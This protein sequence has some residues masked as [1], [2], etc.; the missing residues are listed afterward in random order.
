MVERTEKSALYEQLARVGKAVS[1]PARLELLDLLAQAPRT[2]E[3]LAGLTRLSVANTSQHLQVLRAAG[4]VESSKDGL[5]VT[6][7]LAS[8][9][10][11]E[12]S[13]RLRRAWP[14]LGSPS[15]TASKTSSSRRPPISMP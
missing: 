3:A 14:R 11:A 7:R 15:S 10:V 5:Y 13:V 6:Y 9:D 2:V 12:F 4:L 8:N 1:A